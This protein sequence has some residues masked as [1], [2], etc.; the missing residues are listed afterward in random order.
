MTLFRTLLFRNPE[1]PGGSPETKKSNQTEAELNTLI[2]S[3]NGLGGVTD[4]WK[5][6]SIAS[7]VL[8]L[9]KAKE[10]FD[11][12]ASKYDPAKST[13][14]DF[15]EVYYSGPQAV[16]RLWKLLIYAVQMCLN[17]DVDGILGPNT[18]AAI[19]KFQRNNGLTAD[20]QCGPLT[21]AVLLADAKIQ[22]GD[23]A[24]EYTPTEPISSQPAEVEEST[25][26]DAGPTAAQKEAVEKTLKSLQDEAKI[27]QAKIENTRT[28]RRRNTDRTKERGDIIIQLTKQYSELNKYSITSYGRIN[29]IYS[30]PN[31]TFPDNTFEPDRS[32]IKY[33]KTEIIEVTN[34]WNSILYDLKDKTWLL[35]FENGEAVL[36]WRDTIVSA[37]VMKKYKLDQN[38]VDHINSER[39]LKK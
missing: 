11:A 34:L 26:P 32:D 2:A 13:S 18:K 31:N 30:Y 23:A 3:I 36:K 29:Y 27:V 14:K 25:E 12:A 16:W 19:K 17:T 10:L 33:N 38:F 28:H 39:G 4:I 22:K 7:S 6:I 24:Q 15:I 35:L 37:E 5:D 9:Q 8:I 1:S 20:G 21:I